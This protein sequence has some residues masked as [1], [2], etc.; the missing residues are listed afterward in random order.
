MFEARAA[1]TGRACGLWTGC[2]PGSTIGPLGVARNN[3]G[4]DSSQ[5][6]EPGQTLFRDTSVT[7]AA[8]QERRA[9]GPAD[10]DTGDL[11]ADIHAAMLYG[12]G[13]RRDQ[14]FTRAPRAWERIVGSLLAI[15]AVVCTASIVL[16][17]TP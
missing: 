15:L 3:P 12:A 17:A 6:Q 11:A 2:G 4:F 5:C 7:V 8:L 1:G 14:Y 13:L 16:Y 10:P 9:F